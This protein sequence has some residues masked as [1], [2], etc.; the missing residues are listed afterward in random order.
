MAGTPIQLTLDKDEIALGDLAE[1]LTAFT[2]YLEQ[3][4]QAQ[5][6]GGRRTHDF[7]VVSL[8]YNSPAEIVAVAEPRET[9]A[10]N[11]PVLAALAVRGVRDIEAGRGR[12][13]GVPYEALENLRRLAG[14]ATNG[15]PGAII[16]A[17]TLH[18]SAPVTSAL[19]VQV[20]RVLSQGD[21]IGA[22]E[23][24]LETI[25][26]HGRQ[27]FTLYDAVSGRGVRC[28]FP[29]AQRANVI[30]ALGKKVIAH[31]KLRRDPAGIP[32]EMRDLDGFDVLGQTRGSPDTLPGVFAGLD[33][34]G[35]L[36]ELRGE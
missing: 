19:A 10:D 14:F 12:P 4:D 2:G 20:E 25:S 16:A 5:S 29:D 1:A 8:S 31:G 6:P 17:P 11:G 32:R 24:K 35:Y 26:V 15:R 36:K 18:T 30:K 34:T 27:Y 33:V 28:Y 9:F 22:I 7:R 3:L 13:E 21:S 23:G